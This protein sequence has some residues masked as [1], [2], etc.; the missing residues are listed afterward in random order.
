MSANPTRT[1]QFRHICTQSQMALRGEACCEGMGVEVTGEARG[2]ATGLSSRCGEVS[3]GLCS[4]PW[5]I[6]SHI[7][8]PMPTGQAN[9]GR[10]DKMYC[11]CLIPP[12]HCLTSVLLLTRV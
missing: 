2:E 11:M 12:K 5:R 9:T 1:F 10:S 3:G 4:F 6:I 8:R 7:M